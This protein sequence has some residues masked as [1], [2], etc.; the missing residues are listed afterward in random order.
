MVSSST[1]TQFA[2]A[3]TTDHTN[4]EDYLGDTFH[5]TVGPLELALGLCA[6]VFNSLVIRAQWGRWRAHVIPLMYLLIGSCDLLTGVSGV[7]TGTLLLTVK[8]HPNTALELSYPAYFIYSITFVTSVYLNL[9]LAVIRVVSISH[10]GNSGV[11]TTHRA[12]LRTLLV[13]MVVVYMVGWTAVTTYHLTRWNHHITLLRA[14]IYSP[15]QYQLL[16]TSTTT[17]QEECGN[18][19]L[20]IGVP[21][22]LPSCVVL[23]CMG[24]CVRSLYKHRQN[25]DK[26]QQRHVT[27]T[28]LML[29]GL[30]FVCNTLFVYWPIA[31]CTSMGGMGYE[32]ASRRAQAITRHLTGVLA[33][34]VNAA[35]SPLIIT[36]RGKL[37]QQAQEQ[38]NR[39]D[40]VETTKI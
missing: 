12:L 4:T 17:L 31:H 22:L 24:L 9:T 19:V 25:L 15:G 7:L 10:L 34:F 39:G 1:P 26:A 36:L 6:V 38:R 13:L 27:V 33:P 37:Y 21:Y 32:G 35:I 5:F 3:P 18:I 29:T 30:F 40:G 28:V 2:P 20:L 14:Y 8:S 16:Y 23:G 11:F